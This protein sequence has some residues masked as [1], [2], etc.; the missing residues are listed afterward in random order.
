[1]EAVEMGADQQHRDE[2]EDD[3][4]ALMTLQQR[5]Q[6]LQQQLKS[7]PIEWHR[8]RVRWCERW[9]RESSWMVGVAGWCA[10]QTDDDSLP[11]LLHHPPPQTAREDWFA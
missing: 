6:Q 2:S 9:V 4:E 8:W 7:L 3:E 10:A 11:S 5:R 1:M